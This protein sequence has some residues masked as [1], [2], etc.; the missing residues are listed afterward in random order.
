MLFYKLNKSRSRE[1]K[2]FTFIK[3]F[4]V[5]GKVLSEKYRHLTKKALRTEDMQDLL[6]AFMG[7]LKYFT[8]PAE[9]I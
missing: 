2:N 1:E 4:G 5:S 8:L 9:T 6:F 7:K 3:G